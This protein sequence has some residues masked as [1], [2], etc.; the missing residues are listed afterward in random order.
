MRAGAR[1]FL[2][3]ATA[4]IACSPVAFA[5]YS[6]VFFPSNVGPFTPLPGRFNLGAL[7]DN[8]VQY[9]ISSQGP[10]PL[11]AGD[12]VTAIYS[13]IE[14]AAQVWDNVPSSALRLRFGGISTVGTPQTTPGIDVVFDDDMPPGVLAQTKPTFPADLSFLG[15]QGAAFVPILRS[16]VQLR[17]DLTAPGY[18]QPSFSDAFFMTLVHEFGH[19]LGLQHTFTSA[20]M[21]TAI[22]RATTKGAPLAADD[23]AGISLLYPAGG[24][25]ASTGSI[26]GRVTLPSGPVNLASVV[27]ISTTGTAVSGF[28]NPDGTYRIDGIPPGQYYVYVHPLPPAEGGEARPGDVVP[29]LDPQGDGF[30]ANLGFASQFYP[31]TRDWTQAAPVAVAA[32]KSA[33]HVDFAVSARSSG[34]AIYGMQ[35]YGYQN[36]VAIAAAP[37]PMGARNVVVFYA[38]GATVNNQTAITPGLSASFLGNVAVIEPGSLKYYT[39]GFLEAIIDTPG[40]LAP[41]PIAMVFTVA[42][43]MYVLPS[44]FTVMPGPP[45]SITGVSTTTTLLG[46]TTTVTGTNLSAKT[47]ILFDGAPAQVLSA[48]SDGS[49]TIAEPPA[50]SAYTASVEAVNSDGQT[51]S[52]ALGSNAPPAYAYPVRDAVKI[53]PTPGALIA[54]TDSFLVISGINTHFAEGQTAVGFGSSD[55]AIRRMWV[56][57]PQLILMNVSVA[58]GT[59]IGTVGITVSTG[60]EIVNSP[61]SLT[62]AAPDPNQVSLRVPV[63]NAATGLAGVPGGGTALIATTGLPSSI[64]GWTLSIGNQ[65]ATFSVDA[66]GLITAQVPPALAFGPQL[67]Q[68]TVPG[69]PALAP[70]AILMQ[71]DPPPPV[72]V[73]AT[74]N[75]ANHG[76]GSPVNATTPAAPG[77]TINLMVYFLA[78]G[79]GT[80]P[81]A[82]AVWVNVGGTVIP[83]TSVS[84]VPQDPNSPPQDYCWVQ[85]VMPA[86]I[87]VDPNNPVVPVMVGSG[88]R[89]SAAFGLNV[90]SQPPAQ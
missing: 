2:M 76:A 28:S 74:D 20:T 17:R 44:A 60:L 75:S 59:Q 61:G 9:F 73:A 84:L 30:A 19:A 35:T 55:I 70:P 10:G 23:I 51:S 83:A 82:G 3:A 63:M 5:Y 81:P 53:V 42:D 68:L 8:T 71:L 46:R 34:P 65:P 86:G 16:R 26:T 62:V 40:V 49:L 85:F 37:L 72:I 18:Q 7:K 89:L 1:R 24:F 56:A 11:M 79:S 58:P 57:G 39:S 6:W 13:Q 33:D 27:A 52:Q 88:T 12:S 48:N 45:P 67:V 80:L 4:A 38:P 32:G 87:A 43:D 14:R 69:N 29:P 25:L 47:R 15:A 31:G 41:T 78:G 36:G 22:T 66:N 54:G 50:L 90:T 64:A 77:D 21:S